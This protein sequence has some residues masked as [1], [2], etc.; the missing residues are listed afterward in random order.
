MRTFVVDFEGLGLV[1]GQLLHGVGG[2]G[3][4]GRHDGMQALGDTVRM[5]ELYA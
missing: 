4:L 5:S 1:R 3:L 2:H